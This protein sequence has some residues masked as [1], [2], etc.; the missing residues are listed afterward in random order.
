MS[1][2][3]YAGRV[4]EVD[5]SSGRIETMALDPEVAERFIGG[6]GFGIHTLYHW[7]PVGCDPLSP[8]NIMVFAAGPL[9]GTAAPASGRMEVCTKSPATGLWLDSNAGGSFGPEL[10]YA[11]YDALVI[12]GAAK[13]PVLLLI[14]DDTVALVAAQNHWGS[15]A[16]ETHER[17]K[18]QFSADHR[19]ACIGQ[20]G[21]LLSPLANIL[22]EHRSFGRG[23]AGAVMGS[24]NLKA[25]V[26]RGSGHLLTAEPAEF[27]RMIRESVNELAN[28]PD[29]GAAKPEFGT[30]VILSLMDYTGIHPTKNFHRSTLDEA[31]V[32]EHQ[33]QKYFERNRAC[34]S[35][36]IRCSKI[37]RV[38][39]GPLKGSFTE[40]PEYETVWSFGAHC[41]NTDI[42]TIIEAEHLC[43]AYGMD[44]ISVGNVVGFLMDC[45]ERGLIDK[46]ET[47]G[48]EMNWGNPEAIIEAVHLI[49]RRAGPGEQWSLG[50]KRLEKLIAGAQGLGAHV[51]G[52]ELP[53]YDPRASKGMA[54]AY[55]TSDRG[56]C[57][58]RS[59]PIGEEIMNSSN[60]LGLHTT[61]FKPEIVK[62]QQD[63]FCLVNC[64]GLCLFAAFTLSL[65]QIAP[66]FASLTGIQSFAEADNLLQ[67]G[68]R[69]NNLVRL[70]NLREGLT[71][72]HDS[73]PARFKTEP[74][75]DGPCRGEVVDVD[76]MVQ[77]Y[78]RVRGWT[79]DGCPTP[80]LLERL[81]IDVDAYT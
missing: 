6:K 68:E 11:G 23:G 19:V 72:E 20:S 73:L 40:G 10:K 43:D 67:A 25:V 8:D 61:E 7:L 57:H 2:K 4:L 58:L 9:T 44:A 13:T 29:T 24:K 74:L 60:P 71:R 1:W 27:K 45:Y 64:S 81:E 15:D 18:E 59:W 42:A 38:K 78:Y 70:F 75:P 41:A 16:I 26:V 55:A 12:S 56:G 47:D 39:D 54:L 50:V 51:K 37:A 52:L 79:S 76:E 33:I 77:T 65:E 69:I 28:S 62:S 32:D 36:T 22:T 34:F 30:N 46:S 31:P 49:G 66:L 3:G 80:E 21:E 14:E 17:L 35:C 53:A 63:F 5:L 48:L